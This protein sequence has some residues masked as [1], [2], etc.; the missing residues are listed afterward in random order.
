VKINLLLDS[1]NL[2]SGYINVDPFAA[3]DDPYKV[4]GDVMNLDHLVEAG[5]A[6]D[7][8]ALDIIDYAPLGAAD[9]VLKHWQSKLGH[10]GTLTVSCVDLF[11][12][13]RALWHRQ[14]S[15][16]DANSIVHGK[17]SKQWEFKKGSYSLKTLAS[18]MEENGLHVLKKLVSDYRAV[19]VAQRP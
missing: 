8:V 7:L 5:E 11:E 9:M 6:T 10:G 16:E 4:A 18:T 17:Q 3:V 13:A 19:V 1:P 15:L 2:R 12:V 14:L